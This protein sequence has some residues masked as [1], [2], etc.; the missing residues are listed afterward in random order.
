MAWI[1]I[2]SHDDADDDE[3]NDDD[4]KDV[5]FAFI[6]GGASVRAPLP[7][8]QGGKEVLQFELIF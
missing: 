5:E 4:T 3:M 7:A 6:I 2:T 1:M 8:Q